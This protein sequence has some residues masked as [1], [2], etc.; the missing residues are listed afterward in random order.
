MTFANFP[1]LGRALTQQCSRAVLP[2]QEFAFLQRIV[3]V[4]TRTLDLLDLVVP[5][6]N[7][8]TQPQLFSCQLLSAVHTH[9]PAITTTDSGSRVIRILLHT[10]TSNLLSSTS[11]HLSVRTCGSPLDQCGKRPASHDTLLLPW[12]HCHIARLTSPKYHDS[13]C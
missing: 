7:S 2:E 8:A 4:E 9:T 11:P 10:S 13:Q 12:N 6:T 1:E 3:L 5:S